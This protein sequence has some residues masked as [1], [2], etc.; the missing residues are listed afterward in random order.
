MR[1]FFGIWHFLLL[2]A[3][4]LTVCFTGS[5][6]A[7]NLPSPT[8]M[9]AGKFAP[10]SRAAKPLSGANGVGRIFAEARCRIL[11]CVVSPFPIQKEESQEKEHKAN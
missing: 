4:H 10:D 9:I 3:R 1:S 7:G 6:G 5:G 8:R 11:P 2:R